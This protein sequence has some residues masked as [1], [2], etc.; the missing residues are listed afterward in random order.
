MTVNDFIRFHVMRHTANLYWC[1]RKLFPIRILLCDLYLRQIPSSTRFPHP[2]GITIG[3]G[4]RIGEN[5]L[6]RQNTTIG[7]KNGEVARATIG[8]HVE[9]GAGAI[10]LGPVIIGDRAIIGAGAVVLQ[11]VPAGAVAVGNPARII[12][13]RRQE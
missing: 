1:A 6:I 8:N 9:I 3:D 7:T 11:D 12:S 4:V 5:C 13:K 10:I 2:Y